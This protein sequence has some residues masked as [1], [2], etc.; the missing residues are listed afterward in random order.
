MAEKRKADFYRV[1]FLALFFSLSFFWAG[2][3]FDWLFPLYFQWSFT[4]LFFGFILKR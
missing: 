4:S 3:V 2:F 1:L